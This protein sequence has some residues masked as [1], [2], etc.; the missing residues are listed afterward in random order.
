MQT[1]ALTADATW[2]TGIKAKLGIGWHVLAYAGDLG[3]GTLQVSGVMDDG[4]VIP[5]PDGQLTAAT[6]DGNSDA[7]Q[8]ME[9]RTLGEIHVA[10]TGASSPDCTLYVE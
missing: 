2:S 7:V 10:L 6:V 1:K 5:V 9:F 4:T 8:Q 3:G